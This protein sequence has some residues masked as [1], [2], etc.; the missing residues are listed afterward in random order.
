MAKAVSDF[1]KSVPDIRVSLFLSDNSMRSLSLVENGFDLAIRLAP[2]PDS[3]T[4]SRRIGTVR[5]IACAAPSYLAEY[6]EPA[7]PSDLPDH[8]CLM[9][10]K[11][12]GV[13]QFKLGAKRHSIR[14]KGDISTNS[15]IVLRQA[16]L[17]GHG[18]ALLP[19]YC[20]D[21]DVEAA[22]LRLLFPGYTTPEEPI[23][24]VFPHRQ[25]LPRKVGAFI[26]FMIGWL[27]PKARVMHGVSNA[28]HGELSTLS[29]RKAS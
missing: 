27:R 24:A 23:I 9:N 11:S 13:W 2:Q 12:H 19:T 20:I 8:R 1:M 10:T 21:Q 17:D 29:Q 28:T 22:R 18:I 16:A 7:M 25:P 26:E 3:T 4:A 14:I 5:W 6:G 15:V